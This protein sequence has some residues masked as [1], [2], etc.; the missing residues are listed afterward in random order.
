MFLNTRK[1]Y[2]TDR[3]CY[4]T[5]LPHTLFEFK[6]SGIAHFQAMAAHSIEREC[7][8]YIL[9]GEKSNIE[10]RKNEFFSIM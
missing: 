4:M 5:S 1:K 10:G 3:V 6:V 2:H 7:D 9:I 8:R